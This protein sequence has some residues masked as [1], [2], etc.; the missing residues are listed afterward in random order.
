[1]VFGQHMITSG[2]T[3]S[4]IRRLN[5]LDDRSL[6]FNR[7]V[8]FEI[9]QKQTADQMRIKHNENEKRYNLRSR[10]VSF[11][12]GQEV[13]RRNFKQS[14][15]Q[16][17]YNVKFGPTFVKSRVRKKMGTRIM[18]WKTSKD[19]LW[20]RIMPRTFGSKSVSV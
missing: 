18:S 19:E 17:G 2:S 16:T 13:Y 10:M 11:V 3:Y 7:Q 1:M 5:L 15:F 6:K 12:E 14:C 8:S 9:M 4:L 20:G